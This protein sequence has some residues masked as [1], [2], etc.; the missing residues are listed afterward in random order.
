MTLCIRQDSG[1][2]KRLRGH[3]LPTSAM[4]GGLLLNAVVVAGDPLHP[5]RR[6][7]LRPVQPGVPGPLAGPDRLAA[8][9]RLT[10]CAA[11]CGHVHAG[12]ERRSPHPPSSTASSSRSCSCRACSSPLSNDSW[13]AR[14]G[15]VFPIRHFVNAVF[16]AFDRARRRVGA[17]L[18]VVRP[19]RHGRVGSSARW[20][21][22]ATSAGSPAPPA[23]EPSGSG[24]H[25]DDAG[26]TGSGARSSQ[27]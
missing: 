10:F 17:R 20:S 23:P 5:H 26:L 4:L 19:R 1:I 18:V 8:R 11:R 12:A 24:P 27:G 6:D 15:D 21:P 25:L 16:A 3:P 7:G 22:S 13:L 2:L 14:V 9:R